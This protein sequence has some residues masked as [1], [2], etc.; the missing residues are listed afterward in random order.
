MFL[1]TGLLEQSDSALEVIGTMAHETGHVAHG[2]LSRLPEMEKQAL[3]QALGSLLIAGAAGVGSG[4]A[5]V[6]VGTMLGGVSM[7]ER[8]FLSFTRVQEENADTAAMRFLDRVKWSGQGLLDLFTKLEQEEALSAN[9]MDPYL[10]TH[11]LTRDRIAFV[12]RHVEEMHGQD[13]R[14]PA[15]FEPRFQMTKAKLIG[16]LDPLGT[17]TQRYKAQDPS[18][19]A[20]YARAVVEHRTGHSDRAVRLLD[21][22]IAEQPGNPYL[23][24][25]KGQMLF[26]SGQVRAAIP[27]YQTALRLA[28]DEALIHQSLGHVMIETDDKTMLQPAIAQLKL[29][30]RYEQDDDATWHMLGIAFGRLGVMGEAN[31]ALAEES[32]LLG[33]LPNARR[34]AR[35][36]AE[37]LPVG[38]AKV[39]ALDISNAVRKENRP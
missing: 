13:M 33:D 31:L 37:A 15:D 29:A 5:G 7:A 21:G 9:R 34:F 39:R 16:F 10:L 18:A 25:L 27:P 4:N 24:E 28:P 14:L 3:L 1:N 32:M 6:G 8:R 26:E 30:Q 20:R 35:L 11:P 38:P 2:D 12:R 23:Y 22:L 17:V 19:S 36:A